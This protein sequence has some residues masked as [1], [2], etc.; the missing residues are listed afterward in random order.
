MCQLQGKLYVG[1]NTIV[2]FLFKKEWINVNLIYLFV[3]APE[4]FATTTGI[5]KERKNALK[6][7]AKMKT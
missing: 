4:D 3:D 5:V 7:N 2:F 6:T 1:I